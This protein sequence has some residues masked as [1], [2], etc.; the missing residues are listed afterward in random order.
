M[1]KTTRKPIWRSIVGQLTSDI[2]NGHYATGDRLPTEAELSARFGVNRHT[3]RRALADMADAGLVHARRGSGVFVTAKPTDYPIGKRVRF[4]RNIRATGQM[5]GKQ[6]LCVIDR[7]AD[8]R[9]ADALEIAEGDAVTVYDGLS[10]ADGHP[11]A[12]FQSIFPADRL[13][14]LGKALAETSSVTKALSLCGVTDYTRRWTRITAEEARTETAL[15]L[16][17][18]EGSPVI[19]TSGVNVDA[20]GMPVEFGHT[21]FAGDR[22]TLVLD[23][24]TT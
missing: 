4:H 17:L 18:R 16:R 14:G 11:I 21:W 1:T 12:H 5:P 24:E 6:V 10:F 2:A 8:A 23:D 22:V 9:E 19:R 7:A 20:D 13:P 3:V 15:H